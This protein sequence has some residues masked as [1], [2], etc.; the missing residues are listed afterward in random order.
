MAGSMNKVILIGRLGQDPKLSYTTSGQA[1]AN[2]SVAT[3]E[4]YK[5]RNT[6]QKVDKTEWHR[7]TAWRHTAEFVGKYLTKG[8]LVM[9]EGKLQTRKWQD[10]NG[11][12][13]YTTEIVASNIQGLDS[14]QDGGYQGQQQGGYQQQG[15]GGQYNNN[16]QQQGGGYQGQPQQQQYN[17]NQQPQQQQQ[18]GGF[19]EEEDLGP[20][21]PSEASGMDEVPF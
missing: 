12:D 4:G 20:A 17:N 7:V 2:I 1:F 6:G 16:N 11:Q 3:D 5:D 18:G 21:F 9:V 19:Q 15:S 10:Q 8:R 13:R 14:R